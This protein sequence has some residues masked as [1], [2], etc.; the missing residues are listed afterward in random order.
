MAPA[1]R[2]GPRTK[3]RGRNWT[4]SIS[5]DSARFDAVARA[6][7]ASLTSTPIAFGEL[8]KTVA[9][10]LPR[11]RGSIAWYTIT[12]LRELEVRGQVVRRKKPVRYLRMTSRRTRRSAT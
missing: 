5:V 4:R 12:T 9:A 2:S 6:I 1:S 3:L 8:A 11:F 7:L 10:R